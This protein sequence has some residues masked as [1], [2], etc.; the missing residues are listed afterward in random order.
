MSVIYAPEVQ[1]LQQFLQTWP[2]STTTDSS[3][4]WI[5]VRNPAGDS[6]TKE[7]K[8][9]DDGL[10]KAWS[11]LCLSRNDAVSCTDLH[12]LAVEYSVLGGKWMIF[13]NSASVDMDWSKVAEG[14]TSGILGIVA[15]VST[16]PDDSGMHVI[17]VFTKN[18]LDMD[19][20]KRVRQGLRSLGFTKKL[21]YKPN[22]FTSCG[23][24]AKNKWKIPASCYSE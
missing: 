9:D 18:Y 19:D 5:Y 21:K 2:L 7:S 16:K 14:V 15:D 4:S 13:S 6:A 3:V 10:S 17:C 24:F 11:S 1:S 20:V 23:V 22:A 8:A 12:A